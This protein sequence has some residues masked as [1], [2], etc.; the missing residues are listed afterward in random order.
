MLS[1]PAPGAG[2]HEAAGIDGAAS[3][4]EAEADGDLA[5]P[6]PDSPDLR[7]VAV[8]REGTILPGVPCVPTDIAEP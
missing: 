3:A 4:I 8:G 5:G 1:H 2:V 6:L 7:E